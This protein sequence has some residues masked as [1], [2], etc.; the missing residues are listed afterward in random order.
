MRVGSD[1]LFK[2]LMMAGAGPY[3]GDRT[4]SLLNFAPIVPR[5]MGL[6]DADGRAVYKSDTLTLTYIPNFVFPD[7][8][9]ADDA[10][11]I[12]GAG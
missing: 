1:T 8:H 7:E 10:A 11:A 3:F 5:R 4:G 6:L 12:G 9:R 2:E